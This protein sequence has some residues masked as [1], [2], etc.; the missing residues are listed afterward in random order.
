MIF[1][2]N[3]INEIIG[4]INWNNCAL[5]ELNFKGICIDSR[6][7]K[8]D[9]LF[10]AIKGLNYDGHSFIKEVIEKGVKAV[11]IANE[12]QSLVPEKFPY[13]IVQ[14]T[15]EAFQ[16]LALYYRRKLKI[17]LIA[18]T[19]SVGKT[20]T[21]EITGKILSRYKKVRISENNNNNEIGVGL[22]ILKADF[23]DQL[24]ILEMGMRG[25]GQI[26]NLSKYSEPNI[27][28]ITNIGSSHIGLLGSKENIAKAKCEIAEYL[29]PSGVLIIPLG[30][31]LLETNL[32]KIWKGRI[33]KVMIFENYK[34]YKNNLSKEN[35]VVGFF[36]KSMK[37]IKIKDK[38]FKISLEGKHNAL[39]FLFG[40]T[41]A[42]ELGMQFSDVN[43][44]KFGDL[45]GRNR[46][47]KK[48]KVNIMDETYNASPESVK[49]CIDVLVKYPGKHFFIFGSMRELGSESIKLHID[50]LRYINSADI[51][52][53]IFLCDKDEEL[54]IKDFI[55]ATK[56]IIFVNETKEI[57]KII[58]N[59]TNQGDFVLIKGSREWALENII[60]S[61]D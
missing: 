28:V 30:D 44:F 34:D 22:T 31:S 11:V 42:K 53:C 59:L 26:R 37:A 32:K 43:E 40:Y 55:E 29:N 38:V 33:I 46:L 51:D 20:T 19:G 45:K 41:I 47:I 8:P 25:L 50:V 36:D 27:A 39:N 12:M 3:Q 4:F 48:S 49:A 16:K 15:K 54:F 1:S 2:L 60:S 13:W 61:I 52:K 17:P 57:C 9:D 58:N 24:L 21:K 5:E 7:I 6:N 35:Y 18:I 14:D 23:E 10:I 56:K